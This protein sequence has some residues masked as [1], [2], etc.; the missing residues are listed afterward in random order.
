MQIDLTDHVA[1][2][3]GSAHR[4]GKYIALELAR[5][6]ASIM[7]HY[8]STDESVVRETVHEIKSYGVGAYA[9]QADISTVDGVQ[10]VME[11]VR[12]QY[13]RLDILVN[14]ASTFTGNTFMAVTPEDWDNSM[15]VNL[16]APFLCMQGAVPLMQE[17]NPPGGVVVNICDYGSVNPWPERVDHGVSKAGLYMLTR[18]AAM[19]LGEFNIRVNG[20]LPGPVLKSPG[21]SD[22]VWE[23]IGQRSPLGRTGEPQDVARA[24]A[25]LASED[26]ITGTILHVNGGEHL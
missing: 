18:T 14:S 20:V 24:V 23:Q 6:G 12:A 9:V 10:E 22:A 17:N 11:A 4:V 5:R 16:K 3:T 25:Y 13:G 26:Y 2:V 15:R 21:T 1:L 19:S 8:N 7:V